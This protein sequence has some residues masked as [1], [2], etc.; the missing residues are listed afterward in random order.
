MT[1][2]SMSLSSIERIEVTPHMV[3]DRRLRQGCSQQGIEGGSLLWRE[4]GQGHPQVSGNSAFG[5]EGTRKRQLMKRIGIGKRLLHGFESREARRER[6]VIAERRTW[7]RQVLSQSLNAVSALLGGRF[8]EAAVAI[9]RDGA[10]ARRIGTVATFTMLDK[11]LIIVQAEPQ[12]HGF[13]C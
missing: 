12:G 4:F 8:L 3:P 13:P 6:R 5:V 2:L 10:T 1:S 7:H 9:E 11:E